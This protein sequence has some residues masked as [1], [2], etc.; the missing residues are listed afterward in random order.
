MT[1]SGDF[2]A[3]G[4]LNV[5]LWHDPD[6]SFEREANINAAPYGCFITL[7]KQLISQQRR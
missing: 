6:I 7:A 4:S 1:N 3:M 5:D 2:G